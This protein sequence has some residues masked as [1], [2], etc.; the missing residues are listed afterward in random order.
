MPIKMGQNIPK[1]IKIAY[2]KS[3]SLPL[4]LSLS[5]EKN[6]GASI[7]ARERKRTKKFVHELKAFTITS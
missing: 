6:A 7:F 4:S 5:A 3:F 2:K 1:N